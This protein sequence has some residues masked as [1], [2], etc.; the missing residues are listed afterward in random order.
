MEPAF[1]LLSPSVSEMRELLERLRA[2]PR[3]GTVADRAASLA[4]AAG[5]FLAAGNPLRRRALELLPRTTGFS[6]EMIAE[7]LP[8][9][10]SPLADAR[11][12]ERAASGS[13]PVFGI[14]GLVAA[15]NVPGVA[16]PKMILALAAG[17]AVIVKTASAEPF[18]AA[19][20][21]E[22]LQSVDPAL[23]TRLAVLSWQGGSSEAEDAFFSAVDS[24]VAYGSDKT[25][26]AI[27]ARRPGPCTFHGH[28]LSVG[29]VRLDLGA[30]TR[31]LA[32]AAAVDVA[33]YDQLG[34]LSPQSFYTIGVD[35]AVRR[36]F[37]DDLARALAEAERRWPPGA[38]ADGEASAIRRLRDEYE[39]RELRGDAVSVRTGEGVAGWTVLDDPTPGL[40]ASPL[41]RTVFVRRLETIGELGR[42]V[43]EWLPRIECVG[44]APWPDPESDRAL[45]AIGIARVAPLG[46]M[47]RPDLEWRQGGREPMAGI[48]AGDAG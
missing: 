8:R 22:A 37:L 14:V 12:I 5:R 15:G 1:P 26:S 21:V 48:I 17:A 38:V 29:I 2:A 35:P 33:L 43:G 42:A 16:L 11:A 25:I 13:R 27:A 23:A 7:A 6:P 28:K 46:E 30:D 36:R 44:I 20:F 4:G 45:S 39:W 32:A 24:L 31:S 47:Q 3:R 19:L 9:V 41:H 18:L 34:C 40:R 10:F